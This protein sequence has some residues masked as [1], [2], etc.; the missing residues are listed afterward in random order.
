MQRTVILACLFI[1]LRCFPQQYA[2][3]N[4]TSDDG[5]VNNRTRFIFQDSKG[6]LYIS[7]FGGLSVYDGARFTN[8]TTDN[9][10]VTSLVNDIVEMG[11][12]S[13]WLLPNSGKLQCMVHGVIKDLPTADGF[14]PVINQLIKGSDGFYYAIA[15]EGLYRFRNNRFEK[16]RLSDGKNEAVNLV[17]AVELN[18]QLII[19]TDPIFL[20][21]P[22]AGKLIVYNLKSGNVIFGKNLPNVYSICTTPSNEIL[23]STNS[24]F[25]KIDNP[26]LEIGKIS[27]S[28]NVEG[29]SIPENAFATN[30]FFDKQKNLWL[31]SD[32]GVLKIEK[33][34]RI[35]K[36]DTGN[37]LSENDQESVFEDKENIIWLSSKNSGINK[38]V[39]QGIEINLLPE[40][41]FSA[42]RLAINKNTDSVW[43]LDAKNNKLLL[44]HNNHSNIFHFN[45]QSR[46]SKIFTS[47]RNIYLSNN[48]EICKVN[49]SGNR[50]TV[51]QVFKNDTPTPG[52]A[53][54]WIDKNE[55]IIVVSNKITVMF[56]DKRRISIPLGSLSDQSCLV[57]DLFWVPTRA[58]K[59]F[60]YR[61]HPDKPENY[62]EPLAV[63]DKQLPVLSSRSIVGDRQNKVWIGSRDHGL[64]CFQYYNG[65]LKLLKHLTTKN[66]L[67]ENFISY[68]HCDSS[69]NI[70]A[71][72][73]AGLDKIFEIEG[74]YFVENITKNNNFF[75]QVVNIGTT[76]NGIHW[77]ISPGGVIKINEEIKT[78]STYLPRL[79][80]TQITVANKN[81]TDLRKKISLNY[82]QNSVSF[83][84]AAPSFL[85]EKLVRYSF[86]LQGSGNNTWT[87]PLQQ[88]EMNYAG[89]TPGHYILK[90][91]AEFLNGVYPEQ[92]SSFA[93]TILP[94]WWQTWW[95]RI[96][97][98]LLIIGLLIIG[99]RF[100]YNRKLEKQ[101]AILE[102]QQ[103]VEQERARIAADM[104]DDLGAGLTKI[105]Y[106]T[107]H[108][109]EKTDSGETV[110]PELEKLK[111]FSS[112][113]VESMGE[114][115]WAVSEKNNLLSNT[116]YYLR[117]YAVNYCEE[118]DLDCYFEIPAD[119]KDRIVSG[120]I[121]RN[122][123]LLLK[124]SLHNI[125]KHAGARIITIKAIVNENLELI[126]KDDGKGFSNNGYTK[127]NGLINMKKRVQELKG[128]IRFE[129][130]KGATVIIDLPFSPNQSTI[131]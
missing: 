49:F 5:L 99:I 3:V 117:S 124:E 37:G 41:N 11:K 16:I 94:P 26:D 24:G 77:A 30:I 48:F 95:F 60:L 114:I 31:L 19:A 89:L 58:T 125:V 61:I 100:Y 51:S 87:E 122:I 101:K 57:G 118:N 21:F 83:H 76:K 65:E 56:Y 62:L 112:E 103:A 127:G 1:S 106:I 40:K 46:F 81:I 8:Y 82:S 126:I 12:D 29:Y 104:H 75:Q 121:R 59:L 50:F 6:L 45:G 85:D 108:I 93:F 116:L 91:K 109:L 105:K 102:K 23:V 53:D 67:S 64:F 98:G 34:G 35:K 4:Y 38:L 20:S 107:E 52:I 27:Y 22:G 84:V 71:C 90:A 54:I 92:E 130:N 66:G 123:F 74:Q 78:A 39:N 131:A 113:L 47:G 13:L 80:F 97:I 28:R 129:N 79:L 68:L 69:N 44:L 25:F 43:M 32:N 96:I 63:Y 111:N 70:W 10:L 72:S 110:Q 73:P 119:F 115:I 42:I 55:N 2:F 17:R 88:S 15:D 120:N 128:S 7:T 18:G 86:L 33:N 9:G 36:F 14:C